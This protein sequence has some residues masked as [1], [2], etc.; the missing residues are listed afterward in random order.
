MSRK[1]PK[2]V[3]HL[4]THHKAWIIGSAANP[5]NIDP[6][7]YDVLVPYE[8]WQF[9]ALQIPLDAKPNTFGGWK[10]KDG[11]K[12]IDVFPGAVSWIFENHLVRY[13]YHPFSDTRIIKDEP[14]ENK[15]QEVINWFVSEIECRIEHGANSNGH[16]EGI[17]ALL[18]EKYAV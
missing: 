8:H 5:D 3:S 1:Y 4:V 18:K 12:E 2:I 9:A 17:R 11:E 13:A 6:R 7:D 15:T 10:F 16:L 14:I